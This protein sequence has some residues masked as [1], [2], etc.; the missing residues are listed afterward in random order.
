MFCLICSPHTGPPAAAFCI[1]L[2]CRLGRSCTSEFLCEATASP[3]LEPVFQPLWSQGALQIKLPE[4][5]P[6][7]WI[8]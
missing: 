7:S 6:S 3:G 8:F 4:P 2:W 5:L 1:P